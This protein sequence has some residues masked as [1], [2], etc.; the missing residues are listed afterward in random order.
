MKKKSAWLLGLTLSAVAALAEPAPRPLLRDPIFD[1]AADA[2]L[3]YNRG[4]ARWELF[5]TNRRAT[6]RLPDPKDVSWVHGTRI[7]I[8]STQDGNHWQR[9]D[10]LKVPAACGGETHWAP[11]LLEHEGVYHLWL[12]IVPGIRSNWSGP[13]TIEHLTSR[14]L[15]EWRC[16]GRLDLGSEKVIDAAVVR[17]PS[18]QGG[19]WRL[20]FKDEAQDSRLFA[21][22]SKDLK[23]W[24]RHAEPL[25]PNA[26]EGP[27]VFRF[28]DRWW[29]IADRWKG[30]QVLRS[31]NLSSWA[32]QPQN[33]LE[34]AGTQPTDRGKGQH[35]G[36]VVQG[37]R[38][39]LFYF[40]HQ[41]GEEAAKT[42]ARYHQRSVIQVAELKLG[43]DGWL[44][45][46]REAPPPDLRAVFAAGQAPR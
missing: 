28:A 23:T 41:G 6:E 46:D 10:E 36:V 3:V 31:D 30:L 4:L 17:L 5:Y 7:G 12:T 26:A 38:A 16:E 44:S 2:S 8:A 35:P 32:Q 20:W 21:A 42:D 15:R 1:G 24:T 25:A 27:T 43:A 19:G 45:V 9:V 33:L 18:A 34:Q 29:L 22:D 11:E 37:G 39:F 14:D 40:V 13:R